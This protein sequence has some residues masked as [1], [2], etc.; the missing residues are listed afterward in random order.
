MHTTRRLTPLAVAL[1]F[2]AGIAVGNAYESPLALAAPLM[3]TKDPLAHQRP[4]QSYL[5]PEAAPPVPYNSTM[6][7]PL[8]PTEDQLAHKSSE[9]Q[10]FPWSIQY[11]VRPSK[12]GPSIGVEPPLMPTKDPSA[13]EDHIQQDY[14]S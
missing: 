1:L 11:H 6:M 14:L 2:T 10:I 3:P 9:M 13:H 7:V 5:L 8:M 12:A 4:M